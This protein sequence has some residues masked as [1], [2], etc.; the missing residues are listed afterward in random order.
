MTN[1][2]IQRTIGAGINADGQLLDE[3]IVD[4]LKEMELPVRLRDIGV[5]REQLP[6]VA[7][8]AA[9]N[10]VVRSNPRPIRSAD[11]VMEI[12]ELAW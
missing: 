9:G 6:G 7:L 11:D 1:G 5:T 2:T 10:S 3:W 12:L 8:A 4:W